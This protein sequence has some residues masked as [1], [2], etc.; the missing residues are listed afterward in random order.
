MKKKIE[1]VM[2]LL[3]EI[4]K[5]CGDIDPTILTRKTILEAIHD[6]TSDAWNGCNDVIYEILD[7]EGSKAHVCDD[8]PSYEFACTDF[9]GESH[10]PCIRVLCS[11]CNKTI[12]FVKL[13]SLEARQDIMAQICKVL[14]LK[15]SVS[16][17]S[18]KY[19]LQGL[20]R[21]IDVL[22]KEFKPVEN[23]HACEHE[24][25]YKFHY[26]DGKGVFVSPYIDKVCG[27][28]GRPLGGIIKLSVLQ[29]DQA[30]LVA[31]Y[32]MAAKSSYKALVEYR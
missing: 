20:H 1:E 21:A 14:R 26:S 31:I 23:D 9:T 17:E 22:T 11:V 29:D 15:Q 19:P 24:P 3:A 7:S 10:E 18:E 16:D 27:K 4:M 32:N 30:F 8:N 5:I 12:E 6:R 25:I 13:A 28:C 2:E